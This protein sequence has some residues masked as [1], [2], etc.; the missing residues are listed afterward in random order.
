V[1][2]RAWPMMAVTLAVL[3]R[4]M[5]TKTTRPGVLLSELA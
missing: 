3:E 5:A 1:P 2:E 4:L